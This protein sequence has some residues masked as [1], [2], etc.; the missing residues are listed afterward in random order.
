MVGEIRDLET[1]QMA[2]QASLTG[3]LVLSTVHTNSAAAT[4]TRL[5]DMGVDDYLLASTL[6]GVLAQRLVRRLCA[7]CAAPAEASPL[8]LDKLRPGRRRRR[9]ADCRRPERRCAGRWAVPACRHTGFLGRTTI[10]ELLVVTDAVRERMLESGTEA[11]VHAAALDKRHD[12]HVRRRPRQGAA[13]RDHHRGSA[14]RDTDGLMPRFSY[15]AYDH[16]GARTAGEISADTRELAL[17]ALSRQGRF[18]LE[19]VEGGAVAAPRWWEREVFAPGQLSRRNL[20]LLTRELA[21]LVKAELPI[22][23]ALRIV[24]LQPL[25]GMRARGVVASVL[26][27]VLDGASL[28]EALQA[29]E[30]G[31]CP[32]SIGAS[33]MPARPAARSARRSTNSP[34]SWSARPSFAPRSPRRWSIR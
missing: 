33:S 15:T 31:A 34:P 6:K 8:L 23:E 22:D 12:H 10:S 16:L 4:V 7:A 30:A 9:A 18:P 20:A 3:H 13:R 24:S 11:A 1:A 17:E 21:T 29:P 27:R 26:A 28:S 32:S 25:M 2:I 5:L 14:A 19:L